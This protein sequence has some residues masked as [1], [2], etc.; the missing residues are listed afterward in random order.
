MLLPHR[1]RHPQISPTAFIAQ[2]AQIIG[3]VSIGAES[4]VWFNVVI[5]G[6]VHYIRIGKRTNVQ[7][8]TV[9]HVSR[10]TH[11][12]VIGDEVTIGHNV[13]LHGCTIG[14]R[15]LIGM[16]SVILD[17]ALI[18][19]ESLIAAGAVVAPG[20]KIP[21]RTLAIG[22]P[23]RPHRLLSAEEIQHLRQSAENYIGY[24][25]DYLPDV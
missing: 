23:A 10:N 4:S 20:T 25:K 21:P 19:D 18:G 3:E 22:S 1:G 24:V 15:C 16:G 2:S 14:N 7:D 5:R 17:G 6:D 11:P 13:T 9:I 8:G 12:T